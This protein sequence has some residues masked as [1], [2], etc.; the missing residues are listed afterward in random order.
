MKPLVGFAWPEGHCKQVAYISQDHH[1]HELH[2]GMGGTWQHTDLTRLSSAPLAISRFLVAFAWPDEGTKQVA[3]LGPGGH[4]HEL[5]VSVGG[6]WQHTDLSAL[7]GAPPAHQIV[8]G[9]AWSAGR[10]KQV[11]FLGDDGH[12]HELCGETG[13]AWRHTDLSALTTTPL[14]SSP[15]LVGYEWSERRSKQLIYVGQDGHLHELFLIVGRSWEHLDLTALT[16]APHAIEVTVGYEWREGHCQQIAFVSGD[17]H[18]HELSM[19][20]GQDWQH[21]D[22]TALTEAPPATNILTGYAWEQGHAK[23]IAYVG[24][25]GRLH[26]LCVEARQDWQHLDLTAHAQ[27]PLTQVASLS[28]YAWEE[29]N[30]KQIAYAGNDGHIH[31][32][33][34][35]PHGEWTA[36]DL[37]QLVMAVPVLF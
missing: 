20:V 25:D 8:A 10:A 3:Y 23:Q 21:L 17:S 37:S 1:L 27:A 22:L 30:T 26:E 16:S 12:L 35:P 19:G 15:F 36:T 4:V 32:V 28:G 14:P 33:W 2:V 34:K 6:S 31:E 11:V 13:Q 5:C 24:R 9:F 18:V 7:T 29:G